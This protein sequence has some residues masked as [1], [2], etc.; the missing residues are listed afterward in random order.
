MMRF[1]FMEYFILI[2]VVSIPI[3]ATAL[4]LFTGGTITI[5]HNYLS[6]L[7]ECQEE[8]EYNIELK[9]PLCPDCKCSTSLGAIIFSIILII[10]AS[11]GWYLYSKEL[12]KNKL[13]KTK[14]KR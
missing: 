14:K 7:K 9:T 5:E 1:D 6:E 12:E 2:L 10:F 4:F 11:V 13:K 8:L 3:C